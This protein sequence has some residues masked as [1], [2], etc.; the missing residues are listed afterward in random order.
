MIFKALVTSCM[1]YDAAI[2]Y[3][4]VKCC[5]IQGVLQDSFRHA[6]EIYFVLS[7]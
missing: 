2:N 1:D 5:S 7:I 6:T 3:S 4:Q